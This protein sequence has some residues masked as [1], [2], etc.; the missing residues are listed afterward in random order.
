MVLEKTLKS[1]LVY[2][3]IQAVNPKWN[4]SWIFTER[5]DAEV[6]T[7]VLWPHNVKSWLTGKHPVAGQDWNQ[8]EETTED[9]MVGCQHWL[10][11]H[12]FGQAPGVGDG[13]GGL[14]CCSPW[15]RKEL[16]TTEQLN[17]TEGPYNVA[18]NNPSK[19]GLINIGN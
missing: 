3:E 4:Q 10:D 16:D 13:Q 19:E 1:L 11:E 8:E 17:W 6:E 7:S 12:E 18:Q 9:E 15:G 5:T 14:A 2:K